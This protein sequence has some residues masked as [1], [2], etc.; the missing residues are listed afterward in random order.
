M[1]NKNSLLENITKNTRTTIS[2]LVLTALTAVN[3]S[4]VLSAS[5]AEV[6]EYPAAQVETY[7][8]MKSDF[9][10]IVE[11]GTVSPQEYRSMAKMLNG[12]LRGEYIFNPSG[13]AGLNDL[14]AVDPDN[15]SYKV[16]RD[17]V[18]EARKAFEV[19]IAKTDK[20][21]TDDGMYLAVC[22]SFEWK[23]PDN[24]RNLGCDDNSPGVISDKTMAHAL[25]ELRSDGYRN[26]LQKSGAIRR[27]TGNNADFNRVFVHLDRE[28][29]ATFYG[30]N[31]VHGVTSAFYSGPNPTFI[32][33]GLQAIINP[34]VRAPLDPG[35]LAGNYQK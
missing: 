27:T 18:V 26:L 21:G 20:T 23:S 6:S 12:T 35:K 13:D 16:L 17:D 15:K 1:K 24:K 14:I 32:D 2:A 8:N 31:N 34:N 7:K 28:Q 3:S 22:T 19:Y 10:G 11:D 30:S 25:A 4:P 33:A 5:R 9:E 29:W